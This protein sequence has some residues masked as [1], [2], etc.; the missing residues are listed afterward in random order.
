MRDGQ[1]D[2]Q[3]HLRIDYGEGEGNRAVR[4]RGILSDYGV[5]LLAQGQSGIF[6]AGDG[7]LAARGV[8]LVA[9]PRRAGAEEVEDEQ[10]AGRELGDEDACAAVVAVA[11]AGEAAA[12]EDDVVE[13]AAA[14][15]IGVFWGWL[16]EDF[17]VVDAGVV[18]DPPE[19][20]SEQ[21]ERAGA[22]GVVVDDPRGAA[23][24]AAVALDGAQ[25]LDVGE[26]EA[27]A[28]GALKGEEVFAEF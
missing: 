10:A 27:T 28:E 14:V 13:G 22:V 9:D 25:Q 11:V 2:E 21:G 5:A 26:R 17:R 8:G 23:A 12:G 15:G 4:C 20:F 24:Q 19:V 18:E 3:V 7:T 6:L 1:K 16:E